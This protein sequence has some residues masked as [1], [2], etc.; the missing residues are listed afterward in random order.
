MSEKSMT[1]PAHIKRTHRISAISDLADLGTSNYNSLSSF[2]SKQRFS[3]KQKR[4][5]TYN[6]TH[7]AAPML[8]PSDTYEPNTNCVQ[9]PPL[10]FDPFPTR[11]H[12]TIA[13]RPDSH[14]YKEL[15]TDGDLGSGYITSAKR[16]SSG[17]DDDDGDLET[18]D[19]E[20]TMKRPLS[21]ADALKESRL[22]TTGNTANV[23]GW[24]GQNLR[25][26]IRSASFNGDTDRTWSGRNYDRTWSAR[27]GDRDRTWSGK[28]YDR[29]WS[30]RDGDRDRTWSGGNAYWGIRGQD[31]EREI[32]LDMMPPVTRST[33]FYTAAASPIR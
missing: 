14:P 4:D 16:Y 10:L 28:N 1:L 15:H 7:S 18:L 30:A 2:Y 22:N 29:T 13:S 3:V 32:A 27:D 25:D 24:A 12:S 9:L 33:S 26:S 17:T 21:L 8:N 19:E 5:S 20:V 23:E 11:P 6:S 31:L